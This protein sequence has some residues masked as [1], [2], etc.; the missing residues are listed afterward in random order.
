[1]RRKNKMTNVQKAEA[2][3][4]KQWF[5]KHVDANNETR[6]IADPKI[7]GVVL[8]GLIFLYDRQTANEKAAGHT[9]VDN[10]I[11]FSGVDC[12]FLSSVAV[13]AKQYKSLTDKQAFSVAKCLKRYSGQL[14]ELAASNRVAAPATPAE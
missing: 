11:G 5:T 9:N 13:K 8:R 10:G 7:K 1:M 14:Q 4:I 6:A 12:V 3:A 2:V